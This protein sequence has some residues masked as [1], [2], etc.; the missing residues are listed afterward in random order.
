[1][2][3]ERTFDAL[4]EPASNTSKD[5]KGKQ[6]EMSDEEKI[7]EISNA[8]RQRYTQ[9]ALVSQDQVQRSAPLVQETKYVYNNKGARISLSKQLADLCG[10]P[11]VFQKKKK[12]W[13]DDEDDVER[14]TIEDL[15]KLGKNPPMLGVEPPPSA[16]KRPVTSI[17]GFVPAT[18]D[19]VDQISNYGSFYSRESPVTVVRDIIGNTDHTGTKK[20]SNSGLLNITLA[21]LQ[22]MVDPQLHEELSF[23]GK[24]P[25]ER[26]S[27]MQ[28][29][30]ELALSMLNKY[31]A[32]MET[33]KSTTPESSAMNIP[34]EEEKTKVIAPGP[35]GLSTAVSKPE[36]HYGS[37]SDE[38][39][40]R[41]QQ[42]YPRRLRLSSQRDRNLQS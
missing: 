11:P 21:D 20:N 42:N 26:T 6:R 37:E 1:M 2:N 19:N 3:H 32:G 14:I 28:P 12:N 29:G 36:T 25:N 27:T 4:R 15:A 18:K 23:V 39:P 10:K 7:L 9:Q 5:M 24:R 34:K 16:S 8:L 13:R 22:H 33:S 30:L 38:N 31:I 41:P 17:P 40:C 35:S